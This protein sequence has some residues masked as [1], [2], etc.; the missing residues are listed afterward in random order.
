VVE[1]IF[2]NGCGS[3]I[4]LKGPQGIGKSH[5]LVNLVLK[6]HLV[7]FVPDCDQWTT[8]EFLV[9]MICGSFGVDDPAEIGLSRGTLPD[10][11]RTDVYRLFKNVDCHLRSL[12]KQW[13]LV[14]D[15][16][17]ELFSRKPNAAS[18]TALAFPFTVMEQRIKSRRI[19]SVISASSHDEIAYNTHNHR[20]LIEHIHPHEMSNDELEI[21]FG[22]RITAAGTTLEAVKELAAGVPH[23]VNKFLNDPKRF[24]ANV[25]E[26]VAGWIETTRKSDRF[27]RWDI[28][29][30]S[31]IYSLFNMGTFSSYHYDKKYHLEIRDGEHM[32]LYRPLFPA[33]AAYRA[34]LF[35]V[36]MEHVGKEERSLLSI[37]RNRGSDDV[38]RGCLSIW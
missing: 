7:T 3:G 20:G 38:V 17:N 28:Q 14:F 6:L 16:I 37:C 9:K 27:A 24:Q 32:K 4:M 5:S 21:V 1:N 18:I 19:V 11:S 26:E 8:A 33:V 31:I 12:G 30:E 25:V 10:Y 13:V 35:S 22:A 2:E 15:Q 34:N 23:Y 29:Q 36:V